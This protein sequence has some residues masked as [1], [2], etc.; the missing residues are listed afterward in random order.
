[1]EDKNIF[2]RNPKK[3]ILV[4]FMI[5]LLFLVA[6]VELVL[7]L[8]ITDEK[9]N[10]LVRYIRL[11]EQTPSTVKY[12]VPDKKYMSRTDSLIQKK[13]RLEIDKEGYIYP[14]R[15][16][17]NPDLTIIFLGG[18]SVEGMYVDEK[19]RFPYLVGRL[20][21]KDGKKV[22]SFNS[23]V[24]GNNS[25]HSINI[26]LNKGL[27]LKPDVAMMMHN[28]NDIVS[29]LYDNNYWS[30]N[31]SRSLLVEI[32]KEPVLLRLKNMIVSTVPKLYEKIQY[33]KNKIFQTGT[34][35]EFSH[36]RGKKI[37]LN[38]DE[39]M[40]K[41]EKSLL[42]FIA[43]CRSN[44]IIPVLITEPSR[45]KS[46]PEK[47]IYDSFTLKDEFGITY[48]QFKEVYDSFNDVIRKV[49]KSN[50]VTVIDLVNEIPQDRKYMY[51][52]VH[53]NEYGSQYAAQII[54]D[55][56]KEMFVS[57]HYSY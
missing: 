22:N 37:I 3:T 1:M 9:K 42:T 18:S 21:E 6:G 15:I 2:E 31:P 11:R 27:E 13:Y 14:S 48:E 25:M 46:V 30:N 35:D 32:K 50:H 26:L 12:N 45:F 24:S 53:F 51:D 39:I 44:D 5:F 23:G 16:H 7:S 54:A 41:Y 56:L 57:L 33:V 4:I 38:K 28:I 19:T 49:G 52:C 10:D 36:V 8:K 47:L 55:R 34:I 40:K 17:E 43:V 29:L 20:L